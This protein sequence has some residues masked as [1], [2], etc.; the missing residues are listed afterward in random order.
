[1][2]AR[3]A[4]TRA[5]QLYARGQYAEAAH[6]LSRKTLSIR[7]D[8]LGEDHPDTAASYNNLAETLR[9][10]GK[11]AEAEAM[12]RRALAIHLKALGEDHPD[13]A[14]SYNN[15]AVTLRAQ[16]KYAEAEAMHRRAL[17]I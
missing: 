6:P 10:Q 5:N 3:Q 14:T 2:K 1:M 8:I 9:A 13:T 17:A 4:K 11:Y 12:H 15:L 16:G 7:R